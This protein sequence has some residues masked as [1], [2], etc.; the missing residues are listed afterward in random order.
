MPRDEF[1]RLERR[2][3]ERPLFLEPPP[4]RPLSLAVA[5]LVAVI[6]FLGVTAV[7]LPAAEGLLASLL[8]PGPE[9]AA[10]KTAQTTY[11]QVRLPTFR[12]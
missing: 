10:E 2:W 5:L 1:E 7:G 9:A 6:V 12:Q 4:R 11:T 3:R 8:A